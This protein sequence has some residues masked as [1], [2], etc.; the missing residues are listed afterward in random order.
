MTWQVESRGL[1]YDANEGAVVYFDPRNG[2][3]HLI[4]EFAAFVVQSLFAKAQS[5]DQLIESLSPN[6][7][8]EEQADL[9]E[10]LSVI[11]AELESLDIVTSH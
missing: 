8:P 7:E 4:S 9:P 3:T 5:L 2:D 6:F 1:F 11:L 10:A